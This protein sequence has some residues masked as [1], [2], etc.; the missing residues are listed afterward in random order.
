MIGEH[1]TERN[2]DVATVDL[3]VGIEQRARR[4]SD[5]VT[6]AADSSLLG[7]ALDF[8]KVNQPAPVLWRDLGP[9]VADAV[10]AEADLADAVLSVGEI[11]ILSSAG[12]LGKS[13][14]T[15]SAAVSVCKGPY[16]TACGLRV[17]TGPVVMVSYEDSPVRI[18][19]RL[20]WTGH[21]RRGIHL[22]PDPVPLWVADPDRRGD[23]APVPIGTV[24]GE[25]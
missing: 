3:L 18:A 21:D 23:P 7:E 4:L 22:W 1:E 10:P 19:H 15:P 2:R 17:A 12:G 8:A 25:R 11:A 16:G 5:L 14:I 24:C 20:A 13:T 9:D 6:G